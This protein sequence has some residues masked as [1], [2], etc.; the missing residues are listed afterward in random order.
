MLIKSFMVKITNNRYIS[1][2]NAWVYKKIEEKF[3]NGCSDY[4]PTSVRRNTRSKEQAREMFA[5]L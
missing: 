5:K 2:I 1:A 3:M 4:N